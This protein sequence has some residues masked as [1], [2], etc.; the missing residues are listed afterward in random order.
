MGAV[1]AAVD[2]SGAPLALKVVHREYATD[3]EFRARFAR[4]VDLL[5]RVTGT[6][7]PAFLDA[8][9]EDARPWLGIEYV[10]GLTL[11]KHIQQNGPLTGDMLLGLAAGIAEALQV[12]HSAGI[13]HRDL[14]PGNVILAPT[15]PKV[16]DFGIARAVEE[17]A[18]TRTG[19]LLGTPGWLAPEQYRGAAPAPQSDMFAWGGL[20]AYA[21]TGR[22]PFG[23]GT[24]DELAF[25]TMEHGPDLAGVPE[26]LLPLVAAALAKDPDRRP[27]AAQ[28]LDAVTAMWAGRPQVTNEEATGVL[29]SLLNE[30]WTEVGAAGDSTT[31]WSSLAPPKRSRWRNRK[32]LVPVASALALVLIGSMG[33]LSWQ[34]TASAPDNGNGEQQQGG[35]NGGEQ[36]GDGGS[37]GDELTEVEQGG[38]NLRASDSQDDFTVGAVQVR[39]I[40]PD[41]IE[42]ATR[43]AHSDG[44]STVGAAEPQLHISFSSAVR[45]GGNVV[46]TGSAEYFRD[47][48]SYTLHTQDFQVMEFRLQQED[49]ENL[50]NRDWDKFYRST[51][52]E[53]LTT[54]DA[55]QPTAEFTLTI[56]DVPP[57]ND[58]PAANPVTAYEMRYLRYE[59]PEELWGHTLTEQ[60]RGAFGVCYQEGSEWHDQQPL[61]GV[62]G[63]GMP[64]G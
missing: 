59:P 52:S 17:S 60:E 16:L 55:G 47:T 61:G 7:V 40:S 19:G 64:C 57:E 43:Q 33:A 22:R 53:V 6:C 35:D 10:P 2:N 49:M 54:L 56:H 37:G 46:F 4:E 48:G 13:V 36:A 39:N 1:Y 18:I 50:Y 51:D 58:N 9:T 44:N 8:D 41:T 23:S 63:G 29:P 15:G 28:A 62:E 11:N 21:A 5:R 45:E 32:V 30:R 25:R 24:P 26:H 42:V 12:V 27:T 34:R 14:K 31:L 20:V 3:P 38:A